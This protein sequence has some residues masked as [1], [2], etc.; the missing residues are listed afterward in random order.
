MASVTTPSKPIVFCEGREGGLDAVFLHQIIPTGSAQIKPVGGKDAMRAFIEGHM[1]GYTGTL[2]KYIGF[3]DRD[4]DVEPPDTP[5]LIRLPGPKPIWMTYRACLENYFI[6]PQ[7]LHHYWS[8]CATGPAW[9]YGPS[10]SVATLDA[11]IEQSARELAEYQSIRWALAKLKP[12]RRWPAIRTTWKRRGSGHLPSS[13]DFDP[14]L[15]EARRLLHDF[16]SKADLINQTQLEKDAERFRQ[17]FTQDNFYSGRAFLVW[18]HGKDLLAQLFKQLNSYL[19][20]QGLPCNISANH[21]LTSA[22]GA[23]RNINPAHHPDLQ[24]LIRQLTE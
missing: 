9:K 10:P 15:A 21:Y 8:Q 20:S 13:L 11:L 18:F 12:G 4:L 23:A 5:Q 17:R 2:P 19:Q 6:D 24:E 7:L 1:A 3:R 14:C 16:K 22:Y